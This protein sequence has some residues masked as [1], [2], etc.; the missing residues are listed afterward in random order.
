METL[1]EDTTHWKQAAHEIYQLHRLAGLSER[2]IEVEIRNPD[3][4][5][6][7]QSFPLGSDPAVLSA[8]GEIRANFLETVHSSLD[9]CWSSVAFHQRA[10]FQRPELKKPTIVVFCQEESSGDFAKAHANL[11]KVLATT[12]VKLHVKIA[13]GSVTLT[14]PPSKPRL[15][16]DLPPKP[17]PASSIGVHGDSTQAGTLGGWVDFKPPNHP[18]IRC[19]LTCFHVV[20]DT[21]NPAM[22]AIADKRGVGADAALPAPGKVEIDYPAAYDAYPTAARLRAEIASS[23]VRDPS[24]ETSLESIHCAINN[25]VIGRVAAASG[26]RLNA[27]RRRMDWALFRFYEG[28]AGQ[29]RPVPQ[30]ALRETEF[31]DGLAYLKYPLT[32]DSVID[33]LGTLKVDDW[34]TKMGRTTGP[35]TG[36]VNS[37]DRVVNWKAQKVQS[38]EVEVF[39][40]A[41][42]FADPGDSGSFVTNA[43]GELVGLLFGRDS[44][45]NNHDSGFITPIQE[46]LNDVL[47]RTGG[48]VSLPG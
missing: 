28:S 29:N 18:P 8:I 16:L 5:I 21:H 25:P 4:L 17:I 30:S 44:H 3:R 40:L 46:L 19:A 2:D 20:S 26:N 37:L 7:N 12:S 47:M 11:R 32:S 6:F 10:T 45:S 9:G 23:P 42:A 15:Q 27:R 31:F 13:A 41:S 1:S 22:R 36:V 14:L 34:I 39:G 48:T 38:V 24:L 35:S 43:R 33:K